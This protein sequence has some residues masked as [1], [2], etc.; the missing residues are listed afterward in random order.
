[1]NIG[2]I[3]DIRLIRT[4]FLS[5]RRLGNL[6]RCRAEQVP[7]VVLSKHR[8]ERFGNKVR[9]Y[10]TDMPPEY[11]DSVVENAGQEGRRPPVRWEWRVPEA[12]ELIWKSETVVEALRVTE[13]CWVLV[14]NEITCK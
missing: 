5:F 12:G 13:D 11:L 7:K 8:H 2:D 6:F 10:V 3:V 9:M 4:E 1:M 14:P